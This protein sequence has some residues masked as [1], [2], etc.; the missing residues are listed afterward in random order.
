MR[1]ETEYFDDGTK[2]VSFFNED[3][4]VI[5]METFFEDGGLK[6]YIEY[7]YDAFGFNIERVVYTGKGKELRRMYFDENGE[8]IA[9][10]DMK[11]VRWKLMDGAEEGVDPKGEEKIGQHAPDH[12]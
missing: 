5:R 6:A 11:P 4:R 1:R 10:E 12:D 2:T 7:I 8:E 3:N 9:N